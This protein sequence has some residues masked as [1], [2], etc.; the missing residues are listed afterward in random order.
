MS[1]IVTLLAAPSTPISQDK[2]ICDILLVYWKGYFTF[3]FKN[4]I[5]PI[6]I[7]VLAQNQLI[8]PKR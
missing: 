4:I 1:N 6:I 8:D 5:L 7:M 3:A 2:Y